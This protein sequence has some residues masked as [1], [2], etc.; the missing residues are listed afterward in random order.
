[1]GYRLDW[2]KTTKHAGEWKCNNGLVQAYTTCST[3]DWIDFTV[4]MMHCTCAKERLRSLL[5]CRQRRRVSSAAAQVADVHT[6]RYTGAHY[7]PP[8]SH[9][10]TS[11]AAAAALSAASFM[12]L[13]IET[14]QPAR[15]QL[16]VQELVLVLTEMRKQM[17]CKPLKLIR[18]NK[19]L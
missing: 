2:P 7:T 6:A 8:I 4:G 9:W 16:M 11:T 5:S 19:E 17:H 15:K 14:S 18:T 13:R 3:V 12:M 10:M 1:V